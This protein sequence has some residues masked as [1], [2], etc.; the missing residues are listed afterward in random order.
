[1]EMVTRFPGGAR[2]DTEFGPYLVR[3]DQPPKA[4]GEGLYPTPF[5]IFLA[6]IGACAGTYV[7]AFCRQRGLATED[8]RI[9]QSWERD[10]GTSL[11]RT[12]RL[13]IHVPPEFPARYLPAL[14][15]VADQCTVKKH[16]ESAP[17]IALT[18]VV[19]ASHDHDADEPRE[20]VG[21]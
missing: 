21:S 7:L 16:L 9:V 5:E 10:P 11:V 15:H 17:R 2:V 6:S 1:M 14:I 12:I 8:V 19:D 18:T 13:E 20:K 3:M 4:G